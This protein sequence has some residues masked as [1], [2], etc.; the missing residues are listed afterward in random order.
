MFDGEF[1]DPWFLLLLPLAP[2]AY[3]LA[4]RSS[5]LLGYSSLTLLADTRRSW[6]QRMS[7]LPAILLALAVVALVCPS[8]GRVRPSGKRVS[9]AMASPS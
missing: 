5:S 4:R 7:R 1:G 9:R 2:L 6:R 8:L 3:W